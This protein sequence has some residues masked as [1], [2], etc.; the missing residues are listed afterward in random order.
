MKFADEVQD[1]L[2]VDDDVDGA[3]VDVDCIVV[4][5]DDDDNC[6]DVSV[7]CDDYIDDVVVVV[8]VVVVHDNII[9]YNVLQISLHQLHIQKIENLDK[10]CRDLKIIYLQVSHLQISFPPRIMMLLIQE[11]SISY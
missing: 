7:V 2:V 1:C 11:I 4:Y 5:V 3:V 6:D 9:M 10:L 8:V